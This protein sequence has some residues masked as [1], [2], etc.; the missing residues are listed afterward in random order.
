MA[1]AASA[2]GAIIVDADGNE[3]IDFVG[4]IGV[5]N[6]GHGQARVVDA[7]RTQADQLLHTCIHVATYEPYVAL[8]ERLAT[9]LPHGNATKVLLLNSGAEAVEN[10]I[11]IARQATKRPAVICY[12]GAF[13]G[14]T[15]LGMTLTSK[16]GYKMGCGPFAP[17]IYRLPFPNYYRAGDG[18][19]ED[20]FVDRELARLRQSFVNTVSADTVAAV[21][22]EVV[23]GEGG[24][25]PVPGRYLSGLREICDQNGIM[26]IMDEIQTGFGRTGTWA[27]YQHYDVH[28]DISTWAKSMSGG[29]PIAAVI[30][31]ADVMDATRPG[32][33][34]GTFGGNPVACAAALANI[35]IIEEL[36]LNDRAA[37]I[38]Q[39]ITAR[40]RKIQERCPLIGDVRGL[41]AMVAME[42]VEDGDPRKPAPSVVSEIIQDCVAH[43][44]LIIPAGSYGNVIRT[45]CPLIITDEE[46]DRGLTILE[47]AVRRHAP[48]RQPATV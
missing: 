45:L 46:L 10:A 43:G 39:T 1:T 8:C 30:G 44:L 16:V 21:I 15:L 33:V 34:G 14:R 38:G 17:E 24:F 23:Q 18:L 13:H 7:I 9:L 32:T 31:R 41:G 26:L 20:A 42:F 25:I 19:S 2:R 3:L 6:A 48:S 4:G 36:G 27:A 5:M 40:F 28:P 37:Q 47:E 35:D 12:T 29:I 11:K 22:I